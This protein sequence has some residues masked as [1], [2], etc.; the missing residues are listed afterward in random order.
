MTKPRSLPADNYIY[1]KYRDAMIHDK[2][3]IRSTLP[4]EKATMDNI[5]ISTDNN[6]WIKLHDF[7]VNNNWEK[8]LI[9]APTKDD[10][11]IKPHQISL[12][13]Q[14]AVL[15]YVGDGSSYQSMKNIFNPEYPLK[16]TLNGLGKISLESIKK[17]LKLLIYMQSAYN[18]ARIANPGSSVEVYRNINDPKGELAG[19]LK[20]PGS[21]VTARSVASTT[22]DRN[23]YQSRNTKL[24]IKQG[25]D[26]IPLENILTNSQ[27]LEQVTHSEKENFMGVRPLFISRGKKNIISSE[28]KEFEQTEFELVHVTRKAQKGI[29]QLQRAF[30]KK[31]RQKNEPEKNNEDESREKHTYSNKK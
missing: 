7:L 9:D 25:S 2:I 11:T 26:A 12:T 18:K 16:G 6:T 29:V 28:V 31:H 14:K 13:E 19:E 5:E 15:E 4:I 24:T 1:L 21:L 23:V 10:P 27:L 30:F 8:T 17:Y 22:R 3:L 20:Q